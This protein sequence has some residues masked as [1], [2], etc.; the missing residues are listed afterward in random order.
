M[1]GVCFVCLG[2]ICRSPTAEAIFRK[3]VREAGLQEKIRIDSSG[4]GDWH[5]GHPRDQRST[6]AGKRRG[7]ELQ[8]LAR[9]IA[10]ADFDH[11]DYLITMDSRN[12]RDVL[13]LAPSDEARRKVHLLRSFDPKHA[14]AL[15]VPDPYYGGDEGFE[16]V[17]DICEAGCKGLL[18]HIRET[19]HL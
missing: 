2:N 5:I 9:Q 6:L 10:R 15:D 18:A 3:L 19:H 13:A 1:I 11:F 7:I 14:G 12:Q 4:T 8:G 16:R 17:V